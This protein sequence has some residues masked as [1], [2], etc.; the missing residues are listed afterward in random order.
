M[1]RGGKWMQITRVSGRVIERSTVWVPAGTREVR[2]KEKRKG[3]TTAEKAEENGRAAEKNL[4]RILNC[5]FRPGDLLLGPTF[6]PSAWARLEERA[7]KLRETMP[8]ATEEDLL[9]RAAEHAGELWIKRIRRAMEKA[10][11][12]ELLRYVIVASDMDGAT[13]QPKRIHLHAILPAWAGEMAAAAWKNGTVD[14]QHLREQD[15]YT[16]LARYLLRQ[17]RR[18]PGERKWRSAQ[19][20]DR[21]VVTVTDIPEDRPVKARKGEVVMQV[22][23]WE[24]GRPQYMRTVDLKRKRPAVKRKKIAGR[25]RR[26]V[27]KN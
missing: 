24:P 7:G 14:V 15:D 10:G 12:R 27:S 17:V 20:M 2:R 22:E 11:R 26:G 8:E 19:G 9:V 4:A 3:A 5:N 6:S 1:E 23:A 21:P 25:R 13:G 18:R 16:P